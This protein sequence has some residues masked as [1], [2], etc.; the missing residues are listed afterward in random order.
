MYKGYLLST[1]ITHFLFNPKMEMET[2][3]KYRD[4]TKNGCPTGWKYTVEKWWIICKEI[5]ATPMM[6]YLA[7]FWG[8]FVLAIFLFGGSAA[9]NTYAASAGGDPLFA[10]HGWF[11]VPVLHGFSLFVV[12]ASIFSIAGTGNPSLTIVQAIAGM[13]SYEDALYLIIA[14]TLGWV[15]GSAST[16]IWLSSAVYTASI[17]AKQ[18]GTDLV[19]AF[20]VEFFATLAWGITVFLYVGRP[21]QDFQVGLGLTVAMF[22]AWPFTRGAHNMHRVLGPAIGQL[23]DGGNTDYFSQHGTDIWIYL[24]APLLGFFAAYVIHRVSFA[25]RE[26]KCAKSRSK[27]RNT[28]CVPAGNMA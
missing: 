22:V 23:F 6:R 8:S 21:G 5:H 3:S 19:A 11:Y 17:P 25:G 9:Y 1:F 16:L 15:F 4:V 27:S 2:P 12:A 10:V 24:L 13:I 18:P 26:D 7:E 14:S 20:A 28:T